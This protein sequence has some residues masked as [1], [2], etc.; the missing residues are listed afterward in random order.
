MWPDRRRRPPELLPEQEAVETRCS[1]RP[2]DLELLGHRPVEML[3]LRRF[4]RVTSGSVIVAGVEMVDLVMCGYDRGTPDATMRA[5]GKDYVCGGEIV[6]GAYDLDSFENTF[7]QRLTECGSVMAYYNRVIDGR[8][9]RIH[10]SVHE[11]KREIGVGTI[12]RAIVRIDDFLKKYDI[13]KP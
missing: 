3:R 12:T 5:A 1:V 6:L 11:G 4:V 9:Y 8:F 10:V 7:F 13:P 2:R